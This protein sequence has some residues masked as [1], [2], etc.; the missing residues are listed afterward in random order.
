MQMVTADNSATALS[1]SPLT[2]QHMEG[3]ALLLVQSTLY[4]YTLAMHD[5]SSVIASTVLSAGGLLCRCAPLQ[6]G[7]GYQSR[8][9]RRVPRPSLSHAIN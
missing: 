2:R 5:F 4:K 3:A 8:L 7:V 6:G 9:S 1:P